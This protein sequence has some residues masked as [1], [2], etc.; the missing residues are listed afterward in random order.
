MSNEISGTLTELK[1]SEIIY[2]PTESPLT[3]E[4]S[5]GDGISLD[6]SS[7]LK[8]WMQNLLETT[9]ENAVR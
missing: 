7:I 4:L 3:Q 6:V 9:I 8:E 2:N 1:N 5:P